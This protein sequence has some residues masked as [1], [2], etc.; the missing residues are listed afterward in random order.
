[1]PEAV[2]IPSTGYGFLL[3]QK[4]GRPVTWSPC[5]P[6]HYVV[7]PGGAPP[8]G[9]E[10]IEDSFARLGRVT[11]F[12]F[13]NDGTTQEEPRWDR[14][15]YQPDRYGKRWA[16]VL[17]TWAT[18]PSAPEI[19]AQLAGEAAP[20]PVATRSG[21]LAYVTGLV[22]LEPNELNKATARYG[23]SAARMIVMHEL[24]HLMGLDHVADASQIMSP[25]AS[26]LVT[27]YQPGDRAGLN[28]LAS[29]PCQPDV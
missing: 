29:G 4:D 14:P 12:R 18:L 27:E 9:D 17:V 24:G 21:D 11:G 7:R 22:A 3:V 28:A 1:V 15:A 26:P 8:H 2:V 13:V 20:Q 23:E 16:P 6:I 10:L 5:R 25:R 19:G